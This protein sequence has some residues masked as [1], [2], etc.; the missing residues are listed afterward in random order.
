V[1]PRAEAQ[2][3]W[4]APCRSPVDRVGNSFT[5][6]H[7]RHRPSEPGGD[8]GARVITGDLHAAVEREGSFMDR[9]QTRRT[10]AGSVE[11]SQPTL[12]GREH[13]NTGDA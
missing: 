8:R 6:V 11:T 5:C 10:A 7:C 13:S 1:T 9:T 3:K 12:G 4:V 2:A